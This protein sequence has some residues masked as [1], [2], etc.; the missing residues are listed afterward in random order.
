VCLICATTL[1]AHLVSFGMQMEFLPPI[2]GFYQR[3]EEEKR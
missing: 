2:L 1:I 3:N